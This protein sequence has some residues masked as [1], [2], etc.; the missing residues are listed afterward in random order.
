MSKKEKKN[1]PK[2][3]RDFDQDLQGRKVEIYLE[4]GS[5]IKGEVKGVS[6]FWIKIETDGKT[7]YIN[8]PFIMMIKQIM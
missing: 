1:S 8:K 5:V 7:I 2:K 4:N 6:Q 3:L